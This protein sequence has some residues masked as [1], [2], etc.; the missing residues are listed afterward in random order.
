VGLDL[1]LTPGP[2]DDRDGK[3]ILCTGWKAGLG[4]HDRSG[5]GTRRQKK[6]TS[7][8]LAAHCRL[9]KAKNVWTDEMMFLPQR[10][11]NG[12][13]RQPSPAAGGT[14]APVF[15]LLVPSSPCV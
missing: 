13:T 5:S 14:L 15:N 8:Q 2:A 10:Q 6:V 3:S 12:P 11:V 7:R 1:T 9:P 4:E